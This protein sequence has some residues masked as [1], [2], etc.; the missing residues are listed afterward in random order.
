MNPELTRDSHRFEDMNLVSCS[1]FKFN[2]HLILQL[3]NLIHL[4]MF[5]F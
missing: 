3:I 1:N 5:D 2:Y 4:V